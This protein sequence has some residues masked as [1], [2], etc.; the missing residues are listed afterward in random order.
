MLWVDLPCIA[1][2]DL[3]VVAKFVLRSL[4]C[5]MGS[6]SLL[7]LKVNVDR[8]LA[9]SQAVSWMFAFSCALGR[10]SIGRN[11]AVCPQPR[12]SFLL[13]IPFPYV[14]FLRAEGQASP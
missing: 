11:L 13:T 14:F 2:L 12:G 10:D 8:A 6:N 3:F 5:G 1:E 9:L 7:L 4:F